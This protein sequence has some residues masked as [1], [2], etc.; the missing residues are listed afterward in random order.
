MTKRTAKILSI[1]FTFFSLS[2]IR[3][4]IST[5]TSED[6]KTFSA[7]ELILTTGFIWTAIY[8]WKKSKKT[9]L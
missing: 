6:D 2:A 7:I 5:A 9:S 4:T 1:L 8:F 3:E